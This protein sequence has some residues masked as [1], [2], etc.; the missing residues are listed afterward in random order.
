MYGEQMRKTRK[1]HTFRNYSWVLACVIS[2]I[3]ILGLITIKWYKDHKKIKLYWDTPFYISAKTVELLNEEI[4]KCGYNVEIEFKYI[5][6]ENYYSEVSDDIENENVD[7][8]FSGL[9]SWQKIGKRNMF[10]ENIQPWDVFFQSEQGRKLYQAFPDILWE[11]MKIEGQSYFICCGGNAPNQN[12]ICVSPNLGKQ[13]GIVAD[14]LTYDGIISYIPLFLEDSLNNGNYYIQYPSCLLSSVPGYTFVCSPFIPLLIREGTEEIRVEC[15][16]D[17]PEYASLYQALQIL[18][19]LNL[20]APGDYDSQENVLFKMIRYRTAGDLEC[21]GLDTDDIILVESEYVYP[22]ELTGNCVGVV[23]GKSNTELAQL[24][25]CEIYTNEK[26]VNLLTYGEENIDYCIQN[27]H[28]VTCDSMEYINPYPIVG[29]MF[30][31]LPDL[32]QSEDKNREYQ[33]E[34]YSRKISGIS[35]FIFDGTNVAEELEAVTD[36]MYRFY[37]CDNNPEIFNMNIDEW[38][39][40]LKNAGLEMIQKEVEQQLTEWYTKKEKNGDG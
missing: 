30:L 35:G 9:I 7:I 3:C 18:H 25:L 32:Y 37:D 1:T 26:I 34:I 17:I 28:A 11:A 29:N 12:A 33:E 27:G 22:L 39:N 36:I 5:D 2:L 23:K 40:E 16:Y 8:L 20:I 10:I 14:T 38:E 24:V 6:F 19:E 13:Y 15:L 31:S 4:Q 21:I